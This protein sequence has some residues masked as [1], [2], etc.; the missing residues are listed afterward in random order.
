VP[1][2]GIA[3]DQQAALFGQACVEPGM[4]K[5]TYGTGSFVL[6]NIGPNLPEPVDGL[7][8]T[9]AWSLG[10]SD[11]VTY[12]MEGAIFV[13]GA[14]VQWLRDGLEIIAEASET[15]PLAA[16]VPD[17]GGLYVV[18]AFTG[19][20]A[21][22]W[23][24]YARGTI[25]G[26][27]RGTGRAQLARAVVE[28]MAFQT[29][30]VVEAITKAS[31]TRPAEMRVDG[32]ASAMDLLLQFQADLIGVPVKR[33]AVQETT[34]L[35]AAFLAGLAE[36]VWDSPATVNATWQADASYEPAMDGAER[37]ARMTTWRR[38]VERSRDW[39]R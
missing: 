39:D 3:G 17:S 32:G 33:A 19:L 23:D 30:D 26:I 34:A 2:S 5:N 4:T 9:I 6:T 22:W 21:P 27:T 10:S 7:L 37:D 24:P 12:A 14:A 36:D 38:A 31:G 16:S 1:V 28:S 11:A 18:P 13:T 8:T 20:G 29:A 25:V 15:G 35:G